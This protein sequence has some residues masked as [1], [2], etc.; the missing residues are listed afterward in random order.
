MFLFL[1]RLDS[2][3]E[4]HPK[5]PTFAPPPSRTLIMPTRYD[6]EVLW[7]QGG[8]VWLGDLGQVCSRTRKQNRK[9]SQ[10]VHSFWYRSWRTRSRPSSRRLCPWRRG[11]EFCRKNSTPSLSS[12][13]AKVWSWPH[14]LSPARDQWLITKTE[15]DT[16][17]KKWVRAHWISELVCLPVRIPLV[18]RDRSRRP[19]GVISIWPQNKTNAPDPVPCIL[20]CRDNSLSLLIFQNWDSPFGGRLQLGLSLNGQRVLWKFVRCWVEQGLWTSKTRPLK[21]HRGYGFH[22]HSQEDIALVVTLD[23]WHNVESKRNVRGSC[24]S[25]RTYVVEISVI[26]C[27]S[28]IF[29][30]RSVNSFVLSN[31]RLTKW[32]SFVWFSFKISSN[33]ANFDSSRNSISRWSWSASLSL[34]RSVSS[35]SESCAR[36]RLWGRLWRNLDPWRIPTT[37]FLYLFKVQPFSFA[38]KIFGR[39]MLSGFGAAVF[40]SPQKAKCTCGAVTPVSVLHA[41]H[42]VRAVGFPPFEIHSFKQL[43]S[44]AKALWRGTSANQV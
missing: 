34:A 25:N 32:L 33:L 42:P 11:P 28:P 37:V 27:I 6:F 17:S 24:C 7:D 31:N 41:R 35:L 4:P 3:D 22:W 1:F 5:P 39:Y 29:G 19:F 44:L 23:E 40:F 16:V 12:Q 26:F 13:T 38:T 14:L 20:H 18:C 36:W 15:A 9:P 2:E 21:R 10:L 43:L 30:T 8:R